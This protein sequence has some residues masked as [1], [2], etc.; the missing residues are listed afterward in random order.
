MQRHDVASTLRRRCIDVMCLLGE[1]YQ[2]LKIKG[3]NKQIQLNSLKKNRLQTE[4]AAFP[5]KGG[6]VVTQTL[7][8]ISLTI[9]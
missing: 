3:K 4:L 5:Q 9:C 1:P 2:V 7:L 8:N 6:N